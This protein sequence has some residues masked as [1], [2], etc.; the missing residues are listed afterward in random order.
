[1]KG[2]DTMQEYRFKFYL[3]A[4]HKIIING[5]AGQ[6]HPHTWEIVIDAAFDNSFIMFSIIEKDIE[7]FLAQYQDQN[8]NEIPP[9][10]KMNPT[11][12]NLT[13]FLKDKI[14]KLLLS[15][16]W[17][18]KKIEVSETPS[19][20]FM[21]DLNQ[22]KNQNSI[23]NN[24]IS[25]VHYVVNDQISEAINDKISSMNQSY[26]QPEQKQKLKE[27]EQDVYSYEHIMSFV[28][29][30]RNRLQKRKKLTIFTAVTVLLLS[31]V[32]TILVL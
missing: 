13:W 25:D 10:D 5:T 22:E 30:E 17:I 16:G 15:H 19:R 3:N 20:T 2:C 11:L 23:P 32:I 1:M 27:K 8:I 6:S 14:Y 26:D 28:K 31:I 18:L 4:V 29:K 7:K 9:F 24:Y 12:E 21:I